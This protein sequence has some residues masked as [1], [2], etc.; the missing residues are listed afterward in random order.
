MQWMRAL[1][2]TLV[3]LTAAAAMA[4]GRADLQE[5]PEPD[6]CFVDEVPGFAGGHHRWILF[7][8]VVQDHE[9]QKGMTAFRRVNGSMEM[10]TVL[11]KGQQGEKDLLYKN[12]QLFYYQPALKQET[13]SS[14]GANKAQYDSLLATGF[15]ASGK[16]L[17]AAWT[18]TPKGMENIDG[19]P[20]VALDLVSKQ[21]NIRNNFSH[22][23]IWVDV[24]RDIS[25]KQ[26]H[27]SAGRRYADGDVQQCALQRAPGCGVVYAESGERHPGA[28]ALVGSL[29]SAPLFLIKR[30]DLIADPFGSLLQ[31]FGATGFQNGFMALL[32]IDTGRDSR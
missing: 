4:Q 7:T 32:S 23:T 22:V 20:T 31:E 6:G 8:A 13:I 12:G 11:D 1:S 2:A 17:A 9:I 27:V 26:T 29:I 28:A 16:E 14:A 21:E 19:V 5:G 3:L 24:S 25:L 10:V 18:I 30:A 15:G